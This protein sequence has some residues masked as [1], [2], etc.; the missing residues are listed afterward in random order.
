MIR[1]TITNCCLTSICIYKYTN[2]VQNHPSP[3]PNIDILSKSKMKILLPILTELNIAIVYNLKRNANDES[4]GEFDS[5]TTIDTIQ[6]TIN[7]LDYKNVFQIEANK[8]LVENLPKHQIDVVLN[9]AEGSNKRSGESQLPVICDL[10]I[11]Y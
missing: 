8:N 7:E 5:Q 10:L 1:I 6:S 4:E 9:I 2:S 3:F 11:K